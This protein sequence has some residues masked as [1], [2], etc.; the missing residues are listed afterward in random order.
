MTSAILCIFFFF[1]LFTGTFWAAPIISVP[2]SEKNR[3][4]LD[5]LGLDFSCMGSTRETLNFHL[6]EEAE[7]ILERHGNH[8]KAIFANS[9]LAVADVESQFKAVMNED[10]LGIYHTFTE[11]ESELQNA[12]MVFSDLTNL[13]VAGLTYESRPIYV[14]EITNKKSKLEKVNF[15]VTGTHHAR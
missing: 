7:S 5:K 8:K 12:A 9:R 15:V 11:V 2:N 3:V 1:S 10:D 13:S 14:L 6:D 4:L